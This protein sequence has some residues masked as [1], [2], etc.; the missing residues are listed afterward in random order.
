M[1]GWV[2]GWVVYIQ[3]NAFYWLLFCR[4][5]THTKCSKCLGTSNLCITEK[6]S[7]LLPE[8]PSLKILEFTYIVDSL[9]RVNALSLGSGRPS[10]TSLV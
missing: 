1:N 2:N 7:T 5:Q 6:P 10:W 4:T 3:I 8:A 9:N